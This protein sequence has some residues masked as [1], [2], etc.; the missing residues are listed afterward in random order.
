MIQLTDIS[1]TAVKCQFCLRGFLC[2]HR[3]HADKIPFLRIQCA[4]R[5]GSL[6]ILYVPSSLHGASAVLNP[7]GYMK[8]V[9]QPGQK[10]L[11]VGTCYISSDLLHVR[12]PVSR[13]YLHPCHCVPSFH[14]DGGRSGTAPP[15]MKAPHDSPP[16]HTSHISVISRLYQ[17]ASATASPRYIKPPLFL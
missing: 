16:Y 13:V 4:D 7:G 14:S 15:M 12:L 5:P 1:S 10:L 8:C 11:P 6:L 17:V 9:L 2:P 3:H